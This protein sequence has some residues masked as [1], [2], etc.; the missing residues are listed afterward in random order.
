MDDEDY[1]YYP[2]DYG[3]Y[4][5][6]DDPGYVEPGIVTLDPF[7]VSEPAYVEPDDS[8]SWGDWWGNFFDGVPT[9]G[10]FDFGFDLSRPRQTGGGSFGGG[11]G[12]GGGSQQEKKPQAT[13]AKDDLMKLALIGLGAAAV[14]Y[15]LA[16][17]RR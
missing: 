5:E 3:Y 17:R 13:A 9:D 1:S 12:G 4:N 7:V 16:D 10:D 6:G 8:V 14:G 11:G 2:D 15:L